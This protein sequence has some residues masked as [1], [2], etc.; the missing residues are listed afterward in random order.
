MLKEVI[1]FYYIPYETKTCVAGKYYSYF[2]LFSSWHGM[3]KKGKFDYFE[4]FSEMF[5]F[6]WMV[7]FTEH[8]ILTRDLF[9]R[10]NSE[11]T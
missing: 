11:L 2:V 9:Y 7:F 1:R 5:F 3:A 4:I 8:H 6:K 10:L